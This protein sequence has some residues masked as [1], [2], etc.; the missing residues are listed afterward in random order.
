MSEPS[1]G[2]SP[3]K[4]PDDL[5]QLPN[6]RRRWHDGIVFLLATIGAAVSG[7]LAVVAVLSLA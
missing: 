2:V 1:W 4:L 3:W 5:R 7:Y 6:Y